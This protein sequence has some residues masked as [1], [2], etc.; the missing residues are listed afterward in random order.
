MIY[1]IYWGTAG[2]AG[3]YM[4]EIYQTLHKAGFEQKCFVS[5]Y[6]PFEYGEK[7]FFKRTEMEHCR[8]KGIMRK[9]MQAWEL[10]FGLTKVLFLSLK[11][12]P[13][14]INYSYAGWGNGLIYNFLWVLRKVNNG[15]LIITCHDV[16][17]SM[18]NAQAYNN[19]VK[20]KGKIYGLA[21]GYLVHNE[22]SIEDL[23]R[24]FGIGRDK[25]YIHPFPL[26]D[27]SKLDKKQ[28]EEPTRRYDFLFI[29]HLRK[30]KGIDFLFDS[31]VEYHKQNPDATLCIA[32]NAANYKNY[33]NERRNQ[34]KDSNIEL[35]IG[36]I[37]DDDYIKLVKSSNCVVFPYYAG[38]NSGVI[39]TVLSMGKNIITSD[40]GMFSNNPLVSR[41]SLFRVNDKIAFISKLSEFYH[42]DPDTE[43]KER[44]RL[45]KKEFD[46]QIVDIYRELSLKE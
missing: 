37:K 28:D 4:D 2:N 20:M 6:Y 14:V 3:L 31:W 34:C 9:L 17:P 24:L 25:I 42:K 19:E 27:L 11:D 1:H 15:K 8:Y 5:Y 46:R 44:T 22:N 45:Y 16:I 39:S 38:T 35:K 12:K 30:E 40:I 7:V 23:N 29:G 10:F 32:G 13:E 18:R 33:I 21:E 36:F 43:V 26:M 41:H